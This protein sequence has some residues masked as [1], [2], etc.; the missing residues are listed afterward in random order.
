MMVYFCL[1]SSSYQVDFQVCQ[2]NCYHNVRLPHQLRVS[3]L[4]EMETIILEALLDKELEQKLLCDLFYK[5]ALLSSFMFG[6]YI[7][8][9]VNLYHVFILFTVVNLGNTF[10]CIS[11]VGLCLC[12]CQCGSSFSASDKLH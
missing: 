3:L 1:F 12:R 4:Q 11:L 9:S 5:C 7:T 2:S 8:R 6:S 10:I